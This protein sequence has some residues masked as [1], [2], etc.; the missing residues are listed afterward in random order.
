M[1]ISAIVSQFLFLFV[2]YV[3]LYF[4][5]RKGWRVEETP[6]IPGE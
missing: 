3:S 2:K 6:A 1:I 4:L 5:E